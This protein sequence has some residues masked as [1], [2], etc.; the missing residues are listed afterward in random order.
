MRAAVVRNPRAHAHRRGRAFADD[1][2]VPTAS[3][4]SGEALHGALS[5][6]A[7]AG[8]TR[9]VVDGGDGTVREVLGALPATFGARP[10]ELAV[11]PSGKTNALAHDLGVPRGWSVGSALRS[12]GA[13]TRSP[14]E[15]VRLDGAAPVR[16]GFVWGAGAFTDAVAQAQH[17]HAAGLFGGLAIGAALA[18]S[19]VRAFAGPW[20]DPWRAG[21]PMRV[22]VDEAPAAER[23]RLL[24]LLSTLERLPLGLKPFGAPRPGLK[25]LDVA[26]PPR[27]LAAALWPVLSG[28][29]P[30]WL[31]AAGYRREVAESVRVSMAAPFILD[32]ELFDG[33]DLLVRR[34]GPLTFVVP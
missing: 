10:P 16:R 8:V 5:A 21:R 27:R 13:V 6:W 30:A 18:A 34:G 15:V 23:A 25:L 33:G 29:D 24:V 2:G 19:A 12:A 14:V 3:P 20:D 32:G 1:G 9:L 28:R 17:L 26:A 22:G 4:D 11:V 7:R 31:A